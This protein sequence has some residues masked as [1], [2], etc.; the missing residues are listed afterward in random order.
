MRV[1]IEDVSFSQMGA[2]IDM[3]FFMM[4][5]RYMCWMIVGCLAQISQRWFTLLI[6]LRYS[7][8]RV[9]ERF[10]L[11]MLGNSAYVDDLFEDDVSPVMIMEIHLFQETLGAYLEYTTCH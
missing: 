10:D 11:F 9:Q 7:L 1:L 3:V 8:L 6:C 5:L 2:L 4:S